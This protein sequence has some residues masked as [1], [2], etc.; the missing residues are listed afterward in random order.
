MFGNYRENLIYGGAEEAD[1]IVR[2]LPWQRWH[3]AVHVVNFGTPVT[4]IECVP[5][6]VAYCTPI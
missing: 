2:W 6:V 1:P 3:V 5:S 4:A